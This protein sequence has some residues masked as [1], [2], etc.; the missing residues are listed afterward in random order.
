MSDT[1][2]AVSRA[3]HRALGERHGV[4][5]EGGEGLLEHFDVFQTTLSD[6]V[7][8]AKDSYPATCRL[9]TIKAGG[10]DEVLWEA[11]RS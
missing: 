7:V 8:R 5:R 11:E 2:S 3:T 10:D 1:A 9:L 6:L 4:D